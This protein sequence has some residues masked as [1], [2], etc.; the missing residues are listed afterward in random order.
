MSGARGDEQAGWVRRVLGIDLPGS[1]PM[2]GSTPTNAAVTFTQSRLAWDAARKFAESEL[3][4]LNAA[5]AKILE[6]TQFSEEIPIASRSLARV[7]EM[8]D[9]RLIDKL[10]EALGATKPEDRDRYCRE[11]VALV[12]EHLR[13][14]SSDAVLLAL[15]DN[16]V[17][18][19]NVQRHLSDTLT[20]MRQGLVQQSQT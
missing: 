18:K 13:F 9:E 1:T 5:I 3:E 14:L 17:R 10:D 11:A 4:G 15:D 2:S 16:P 8:L 6:G 20:R 12:D 7:L 19:V